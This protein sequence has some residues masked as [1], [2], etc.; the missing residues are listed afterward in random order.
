MSLINDALKRAQN[1]NT[2]SA[3]VPQTATGPTVQPVAIPKRSE[4]MSAQKMV[5]TLGIVIGT[6]LLMIV[7]LGAGF[8]VLYL[9][10]DEPVEMAQTEQP[11]QTQA[12]EVA[13]V[14][15]EKIVPVQETAV[16]VEKIPA[17]ITPTAPQPIAPLIEEEPAPWV[18]NPYPEVMAYV[19]SIKVTGIRTSNGRS[20]VL[21]NNKVYKTGEIVNR[22]LGL[23]LTDVRPDELVFEDAE[24][25]IYTAHF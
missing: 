4:P 12:T 9:K 13:A 14:P 11:A 15:V 2:A 19:D 1:L 5:I 17:K 25:N 18:N 6:L 24:K 21:M 22:S 16:V 10:S 20:R 8:Y 3:N 23:K 7:G